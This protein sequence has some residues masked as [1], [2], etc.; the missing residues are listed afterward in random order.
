MLSSFYYYQGN[1]C[2]NS[3]LKEGD[4]ALALP[5]RT[6]QEMELLNDT[7]RVRG[8][9]AYLPACTNAFPQELVVTIQAQ[10]STLKAAQPSLARQVDF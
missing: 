10:H 1:Q 3:Y 6:E 5:K 7:E 9:V 8:L 2:P 4:I